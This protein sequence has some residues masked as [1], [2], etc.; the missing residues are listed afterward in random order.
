MNQSIATTHYTE[1][2][3]WCLRIIVIGM[4]ALSLGSGIQATDLRLVILD[5]SSLPQPTIAT[6]QDEALR[7]LNRLAA[8]ISWADKPELLPYSPSPGEIHIVISPGRAEKWELPPK[9]MGAALL[10]ASP[11]KGGV[12]VVFATTI[13]DAVTRQRRLG[14]HHSVLSGAIFARSL[15]R[16]IAHEVVHSVA[17]LHPHSNHGIMNSSQDRDSLIKTEGIVDPVCT[18]AFQTGLSRLAPLSAGTDSASPPAS[19]NR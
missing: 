18:Q 8:R 1:R 5:H 6:A 15:G 10:A 19:V 17:P 4:L 7:I 16:V 3:C 9:T 13:S 2:C 14:D 12:T 11:T